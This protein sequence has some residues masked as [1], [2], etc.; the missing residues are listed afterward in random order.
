MQLED[1]RGNIRGPTFIAGDSLLDL[2]LTSNM[3]VKNHVSRLPGS[4]MTWNRGLERWRRLMM[5]RHAVNYM[6][7]YIARELVLVLEIVVDLS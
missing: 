3:A 7:C 1:P 2:L 5:P 6:C 4:P